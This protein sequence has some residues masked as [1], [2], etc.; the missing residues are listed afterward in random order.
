MSTRYA[1]KQLWL[2]PPE[3]AGTLGIPVETPAA[4]PGLR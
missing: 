4:T 1:M 2:V 3:A